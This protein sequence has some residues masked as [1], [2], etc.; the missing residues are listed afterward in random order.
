VEKSSKLIIVACHASFR[1]E[2]EEVV[3]PR[4]DQHWA[5]KPFQKGEPVCFIEHLRKGIQALA[6]D[7]EAI[8]IISGGY[9]QRESGMRWS[10]AGTYL[11]IANHCDWFGFPE[12]SRR[13]F[14]EEYSRDSFENLLFSVCKFNMITGSFP[15]NIY[16]VSWS[17]K[18][19]RFDQHRQ[20]I[21]LPR[22]KFVFIG[23]NQPENLP[24]ALL[25]E[26]KALADFNIDRYGV[27]EV[28]GKKREERNPF[29]RQHNYWKI[30]EL[31]KFFDFIENAANGDF[32]YP[33]RLPW[34]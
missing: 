8:L 18:E 29:N 23:A 27:G 28:L 21:R 1:K 24:E 34:E 11:H 4:L 7:P 6:A 17:F 15:E 25:G 31:V 22:E 5:L 16:L 32:E 14:L 26:S 9:A 12:V 20:A 13:V 10:E 3:D 30:A 2:A 33:N 19:A